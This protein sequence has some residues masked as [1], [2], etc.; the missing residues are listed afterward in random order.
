[1]SGSCDTYVIL[2][3]AH[4]IASHSLRLA[5]VINFNTSISNIVWIA[6]WHN[7]SLTMFFDVIRVPKLCRNF[8]VDNL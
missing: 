4:V 3:L 6:R 2:A 8:T 5:G 7:R 1:M